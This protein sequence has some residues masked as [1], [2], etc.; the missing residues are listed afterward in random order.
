MRKHAFL[1]SC[2][3]LF[4]LPLF[5]D[6]QLDVTFPDWKGE[7][8]ANLFVNSVTGFYGNHGQG[9]LYVTPSE[10][11]T[12]FTLYVNNMTVPVARCTPGKTTALN[13]A[14]YTKDG[15]NALQVS[16]VLP[17][18]TATVQICAPYPTVRSDEKSLN[19]HKTLKD[20]GISP[21]AFTLIDRIIK[22]DIAHGFSA[23]QLAV[24]KDGALIYSNA[25]GAVQTYDEN[26]SPVKKS[27][28]VTRETLF[29]LASNTKMY[30]VNYALQ[31]LVTRS[32]IS[33]DDTVAKWLGEDFYA[34]TI[35][36]SYRVGKRAH[37]PLAENKAYKASLTIRDLLRHQGGFPA[38]EAYFNDNF[39]AA[40]LMQQQGC[41]NILYAGA[42]ADAETREKTRQALYKTPLLYKPGTETLYSDLDYITLGFVIEKVT[43]MRLDVFL[44][45]LFWEPLGLTHITYR[46][47]DN[48]FTKA[49]CA[50]TELSGNTRSGAVTFTGVRR[51]LIQGEAHDE[52]CYYSMAGVSGHAGLFSNAEDLAKLC[53]IMLS[54]GYAYE[55]YFSRDVIDVFTAPKS[56]FAPDWGLGWW[57]QGEHGSD[58]NFGSTAQTAVF[59]H[60]GFTGTL[61]VIDPAENLVIVFLTNKIHTPLIKGYE[62]QSRFYGNYYLT[63][64]LGFT[65]HI[66]R[67]GM[68]QEKN[69]SR[70]YESLLHDAVQAA[71]IRIAEES[72]SEADDSHP[73]VLALKALEEL[74]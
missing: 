10:D 72:L 62:I 1:A 13:I 29:D 46:P 17:E 60:Q 73:F 56:E 48:G 57:R 58:K 33:L 8:N 4:A 55:H 32:L 27:A 43:G 16:D 38:T 54:G 65:T 2:L 68:A 47:L 20:A 34:N 36:I 14:S 22:S 61:T 44:R 63:G 9:V 66:I 39:N 7:I 71:R 12:H 21:Q 70:I 31:Y 11:C 42:N 18:K 26:G 67:L 3:A 45:A 69:L 52:L 24:I 6:W 41:T 50:A 64:S 51:E 30:S 25:W 5:A 37:I 59:G 74:Q 19:S 28:P 53:F 23:A 40:T 15:I 35:D 49:D